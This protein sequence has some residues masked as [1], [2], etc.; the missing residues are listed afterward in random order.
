MRPLKTLWYSLLAV[1]LLFVAPLMAGA[2]GNPP[3]V[4]PTHYWTYQN[5]QPIRIPQDIRIQD[6]FFPGGQP[7]TVDS[8][9]RLLNWVYKTDLATGFTSAPLDTFLHYTW[10]NVIQ[11]F[12]VQ[13][14]ALVTNQFGSYP[15]QVLNVEFLLTPALKNQ[16][17]IGQ[18]PPANHY[19]CYRA[20][21]FPS[22]NRPFLLHD[23]WRQD[24]Q[25]PGPLEFLCTPCLKEH[26]GRIFP[27][28]DTLT[29]L[30]V[31]RI[32]PQSEPFYPIVTDQF[33]T[34]PIYVQQ[35][36]IEYLFVPSTK[37][38]IITDTKKQSWGR[39]KTLYR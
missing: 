27:P 36:P 24:T 28:V 23:E 39:L 17:A 32:V 13:R 21:G 10:W 29:H 20:V 8:L 6:Q 25:I 35:R 14:T 3:G 34:G 1:C 18:P 11:K 33:F 38:V 16:P 26:Q 19:L 37:Q 12:P 9:N 2:Q 4:N 7:M 31:Y 5:L 22:P 30:A 15:V